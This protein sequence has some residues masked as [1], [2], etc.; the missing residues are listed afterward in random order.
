M[1]YVWVGLGLWTVIAF[2]G[3]VTFHHLTVKK[4]YF[5]INKSIWNW[6]L[7]TVFLP[8]A[9]YALMGFVIDA[10]W[11]KRQFEKSIIKKKEQ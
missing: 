9:L 5:N 11:Q 2:I 10:W 8:W 6:M 7:F 3:V 1:K 4:K